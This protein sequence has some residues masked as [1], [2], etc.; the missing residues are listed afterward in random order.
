MASPLDMVAC[1]ASVRLKE[2][3][4]GKVSL[5]TAGPEAADAGLRSGLALGAD[6]ATRVD[7]L[8]GGLVTEL[9]A[10]SP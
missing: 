3:A 1:E 4:G 6:E 7:F 10:L 9:S 2:A 8:G 5:F